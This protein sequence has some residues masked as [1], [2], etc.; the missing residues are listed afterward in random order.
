MTLSR[1]TQVPAFRFVAD[2]SPTLSCFGLVLLQDS[3]GRFVI[4]EKRTCAISTR[5]SLRNK[6]VSIDSEFNAL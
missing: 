1:A 3:N 4:C 5:R 6:F 2:R